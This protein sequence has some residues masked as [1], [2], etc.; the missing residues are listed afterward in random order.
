[1]EQTITN[2]IGEDLRVQK[3]KKALYTALSALLKHRKFIRI[4]VRDLCAESLVSKTA[5]YAHFQDKYDLLEQWLLLQRKWFLRAFQ[6]YPD[7]QVTDLLCEFLQK[8][9]DM[10]VNLFE[11]TSREDRELLCQFLLPGTFD[12]DPESHVVLSDFL[13]GGL[14]H[15]VVCMMVEQKLTVSEMRNA[16]HHV[17][18]I[19]MAVLNCG[20]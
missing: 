8:N 9:A 1:M 6:N 17:H 12:N 13:K 5:F 19:T 7:P 15:V 14:F 16:I 20:L 11:D 10:I 18:T 3:T 2:F 4:T